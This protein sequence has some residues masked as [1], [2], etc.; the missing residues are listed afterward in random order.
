ML[1]PHFP[2]S[3]PSVQK[4]PPPPPTSPSLLFY[5]TVCPSVTL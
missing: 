2:S 1:L 5:T 4:D 3:L